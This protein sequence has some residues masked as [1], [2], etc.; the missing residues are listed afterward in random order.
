MFMYVVGVLQ[1]VCCG[2]AI[3]KRHVDCL[4]HAR[5][6]MVS[7]GKFVLKIWQLNTKDEPN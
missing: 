4:V 1:V 3:L 6:S 2:V 5:Q 7:G